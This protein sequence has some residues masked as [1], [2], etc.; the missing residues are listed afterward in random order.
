MNSEVN[1]HIKHI[2]I[3]IAVLV[4]I[5]SITTWVSLSLVLSDQLISSTISV[6]IIYGYLY[7]AYIAFRRLK[8]I[9]TA[10]FSSTGTTNGQLRTTRKNGV[11][12]QLSTSDHAQDKSKQILDEVFQ[13]W[14]HP[15]A[16]FNRN[17]ELTFF[18][19]AMYKQLNF[20]LCL[21]SSMA[22]CGFT[23]ENK[24]WCHP[25]LNDQWTV[26]CF[27]I[28]ANQ[29]TLISAS[30][31]GD[32]IQSAKRASQRDL[33]RIFTHELNNSLT[34]ISS[35]VDSMLSGPIDEA[36]SKT[37]LQ[38]IKT[39]SESL[40]YFVKSYAQLSRLPIPEAIEF[41]LK[42][43]SLTNATEL[44]ISLVFKGNIN[45]FADPVLIEQLLINLF[46]NAQEAIGSK[47]EVTLVN[48]QHGSQQQLTISDNGPGFANLANA[49]TPLYTTKAEGEGLGLSFCEEIVVS[50]GGTIKLTNDNGAT[51]AININRQVTN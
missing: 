15:I 35:L 32:Q 25:N 22:E 29:S 17:R 24:K 43:M 46:K 23:A 44:G 42:E 48:E 1:S 18:N 6:A 38:R 7:L 4:L 40:L 16:I 12:E 26:D 28:Y 3:L 36:D 20:P 47:C 50:H 27:S 31:I 51:I 14:P 5:V 33:I 34:P 45:F 8:T 11:C 13:S 9:L 41:N 21:G 19:H 10:T 39:R 2:K 30:Y 37:I 49:L